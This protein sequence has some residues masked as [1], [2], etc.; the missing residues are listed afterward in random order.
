MTSHLFGR[1][2]KQAILCS[3]N[4]ESGETEEIA[5]EVTEYNEN[6][7]NYSNINTSK[8]NSS[9]TSDRNNNL[10]SAKNNRREKK[11]KSKAKGITG[12]SNSGG[13]KNKVAPTIIKKQRDA[14]IVI[15]RGEKRRSNSIVGR[16]VTTS[17]EDNSHMFRNSKFSYP[18]NCNQDR[19][20]QL[21][22]GLT[23][24]EKIKVNILQGGS[25]NV[26]RMK[27]EKKTLHTDIRN[28]SQEET[29]FL[30]MDLEIIDTRTGPR[31]GPRTETTRGEGTGIGKVNIN[32][33]SFTSHSPPS[34]YTVMEAPD[35]DFPTIQKGGLLSCRVIDRMSGKE[36]Q[37]NPCL[38]SEEKIEVLE[39]KQPPDGGSL[40]EEKFLL[41]RTGY[42]FIKLLRDCIYGKVYLARTLDWSDY[43]Q[44]FVYAKDAPLVAIK[45][46]DRAKVD[47]REFSSGSATGIYSNKNNANG[48]QSQ[49]ERVV[50]KT[51]AEDPIREISLLQS[52]SS[53]GHESVQSV[54]DVMIDLNCIYL[55]SPY[56]PGGE[57]FNHVDKV[58]N[59]QKLRLTQEQVKK[60][61]KEI[62]S[63]VKYL[64]RGMKICHHDLSLEN[65]L[66]DENGKAIIIDFGMAC[67]LPTPTPTQT[68]IKSPFFQN[69]NRSI[70]E[71]TEIHGRRTNDV[72]FDIEVDAEKNINCP[73]DNISV[74]T[75]AA[76]FFDFDYDE[77]DDTLG[78]GRINATKT[79]HLSV[80]KTISDI[81]SL[82]S[83]KV[84]I[85]KTKSI[86]SICS[87][88]TKSDCN[89]IQIEQA[90][91]ERATT[92]ETLEMGS[93]RQSCPNLSDCDNPNPVIGKTLLASTDSSSHNTSKS[94]TSVG[95]KDNRRIKI[96]SRGAKIGK[97]T[98]MTPEIWKNEDFDGEAI[99]MW[100][101]GIILFILLVGFPPMEEPSEKDNRFNFIMKGE[102]YVLLNLWGI[103]PDIVPPDALDLFNKLVRRNP[104]ERLS[105]EE[106]LN[107]P[108]LR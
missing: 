1:K 70:Y 35:I 71:N 91:M 106:A 31:T 47:Y 69:N 67:K 51:T 58:I 102:L 8:S 59:K 82:N 85:K 86:Q 94:I 9:F 103:G 98:Y 24:I 46:I 7:L 90:N 83:S 32:P 80:H 3:Q 33:T 17:R 6:S 19:E 15:T 105:V 26:N 78:G 53:P 10:L 4:K 41:H 89:L 88:S 48:L 66:L 40:E 97:V 57:L 36:M 44:Q 104:L 54:V 39:I 34:S 29:D 12:I 14:N 101:C 55:I 61:M 20:K 64:H 73:M 93:P 60:Y 22:T 76:E 27:G 50:K 56:Y 13:D 45:C 74:M 75:D 52:V 49:A 72:V 95:L 87:D 5:V 108:Y 23:L 81:L 92:P 18:L 63:G 100:A 96:K 107:H 16:K 43:Y 77:N 68:P 2:S 65:I 30:D 28:Q 11:V 84:E 25:N 42:H 21:R 38:I 99:D 37:I 62:L 79:S